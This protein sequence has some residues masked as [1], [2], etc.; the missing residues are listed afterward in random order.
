MFRSFFFAGFECATG[1]NALGEWID[2]V[3]ATHHDTH[4]E[5][6]YRRLHEVGIFAAREAIRWPL[7]D[8]GGKYDFS[9][10]APFLQAS[11]KY[12]TE[13]IWDLFHYGYPSYLDPFSEDFPKRFADY[14]Y[15]A[16]NHVCTHQEGPCYFT[17]VNEPSFFAWAGGQVGRFAP[18]CIGKGV[19]LKRALVRAAIKG[20]DAIRAAIPS[21]RIV[22]VD[23]LCHVSAPEDRPD[24]QA[25]ADW[26]NQYA[27]FESWDMLCGKIMP[28]LGGTRA[29]LDIPGI[30]YYWTNQW[31]LGRDEQP[32]PA[33]HPKRVPLR[34]LVR[35][36]QA[37]YGGPILITETAHI[38]DMRPA[39]L[40]HVADEV[41]A[42]LLEGV[43]LRGVCL[44]PILS[45]PE[46]HDQ[47]TWAQMGL[48]DVDL[49]A[50]G[51][52]RRV[53]E[54][55][56]EALKKAQQIEHRIAAGEYPI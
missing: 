11:C 42:L 10:V 1:Y 31:V 19:E 41:D 17:P 49:C 8:G 26:F 38:D 22:N 23:P 3:A 13:V 36:V 27:V 46:W 12:Q 33:D 18:H 30:N 43:P 56:L 53:C 45:M 28:E 51:M 32:L 52:E 40:N 7:V 44:Y 54:P 55:M 25:D 4:V 15:A 29:H 48:W 20:I 34:D 50:S 39:W 9:S 14:C 21:A 37:R 47:S 5:E 24:M 2:Q 6:D 16:A 35:Q